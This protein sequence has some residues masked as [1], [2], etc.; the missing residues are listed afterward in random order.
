MNKSTVTSD[1]ILEMFNER[2]RF[3]GWLSALESRRASTP[4]HIYERVRGDYEQRLEAVIA[5]LLERRAEVQ[6]MADILVQRVTALDAD[7][8]RRRDEKMEA[9]LRAAIGE[10]EGREADKIVRRSDEAMSVLNAEHAT[11]SSE[12]SRLHEV[13][14]RTGR[15]A[16][17]FTQEQRPAEPVLRDSGS[18]AKDSK[19]NPDMAATSPSA[20]NA[21]PGSGK[22]G[23]G[24][25]EL[26]F[27]SS[28]VDSRGGKGA[29]GARP[30]NAQA[31]TPVPE[32]VSSTAGASPSGRMTGSVPAFL[33]DVP[34]EQVKTLKC[35]ECATMNYPTEWYCERCGAELAAL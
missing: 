13:L 17:V 33:K 15:P 2:Q 31:P 16:P 7:T 4:P 35:Q 28:V 14:E 9:E 29:K 6:S 18:N 12:L 20:P 23:E 27:L 19:W 25:D 5:R 3:E 21:P 24:F 11:V 32:P 8:S 22:R 10:L 1:A 34:N 26:Q 30:E